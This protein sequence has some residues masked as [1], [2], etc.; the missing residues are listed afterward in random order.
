MCNNYSRLFLLHLLVI[1]GMIINH[2]RHIFNCIGNS[3]KRMFVLKTLQLLD[4]CT[5]ICICMYVLYQW[6]EVTLT[7][8][9]SNSKLH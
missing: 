6:T 3:G 9:V 1:E 4:L 2:T 8:K 5:Y 7:C